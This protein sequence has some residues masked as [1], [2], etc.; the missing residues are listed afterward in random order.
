MVNK[1]IS[2]SLTAMGMPN[3]LEPTNLYNSNG[4]KPDGVTHLPLKFGKS[5]TWIFTSPHPL[6]PCHL[7]TPGSV[8]EIAEKK[9]NEKYE[10]LQQN[11]FFTPIAIDTLGTYGPQA[12]QIISLIGKRLSAKHKDPRRLVYLRESLGK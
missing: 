3:S 2:H 9:K 4:L 12:K 5:L 10:S 1:L 8:A 6:C 7:N 11:Y